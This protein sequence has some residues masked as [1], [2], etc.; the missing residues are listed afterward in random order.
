MERNDYDAIKG[1][2]EELDPDLIEA[3]RRKEMADNRYRKALEAQVDA[4]A[5]TLAKNANFV[6]WL[7][8]V[9]DSAGV[10][11]SECHAHSGQ[12][13]F[14]DGRRA[15]GLEILHGVANHDPS[16]LVAVQVERLKFNEKVA[17]SDE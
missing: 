12:Q 5:K 1:W 8:G 14:V 11:S 16:I 17:Q 10:F 13:Y 15:L 7:Y 2:A 4:D 3:R 6:R 9:L